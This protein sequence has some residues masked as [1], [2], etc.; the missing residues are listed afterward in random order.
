MRQLLSRLLKSIQKNK[1]YSFCRL[2]SFEGKV[3]EGERYVLPSPNLIVGA[4]LR[5]GAAIHQYFPVAEPA[6]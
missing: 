2:L 5:L 3:S 4:F 1:K 6:R